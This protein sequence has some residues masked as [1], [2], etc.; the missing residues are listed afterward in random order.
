MEKIGFA[1][2]IGTFDGVHRGHQFVLR[3]L[4]DQSQRHAVKP[5]VI[6]FDR[7]P[8]QEPV[9]TPLA[10]KLRLIHEMGIE[11]TEVLSFT[12][13][14]K[15]MTAYEFM[16]KVLHN[17]FDVKLLLTGYDNRFGRNREE[18]FND[19]IEYGHKL[20]I[21][22]IGLPAEGNV[23]SSHIR[24]LLTAGHVTEA[25]DCLGH[26]YTISGQI[27]YGEHVG[28]SLGFPTANLE[29]DDVHQL[30]PA[31]GAYAVKVKT[32]NGIANGMMNIGTR[33]TF[34]H[35][36]PTLEVHL[37]NRHEN[38]YG[39]EISVAFISRLREERRFESAKALQE[40][41]NYDAIMAEKEI[42]AN[43]ERYHLSL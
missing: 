24:Q 33:P 9:L 38:L 3:Q 26:Y 23:S 4:A 8:R 42:K 31:W 19:Y 21:T 29:P 22:V 34:G 36:A 16:E 32:P 35:H 39:Q 40:Q 27:G 2:T 28:T 5:M 7:S 30:I 25:A 17:R 41:L 13:E 6:T 12:P 11:H 37:L 20:G 43:E 15:A 18:G 14:L 1:A 10:E